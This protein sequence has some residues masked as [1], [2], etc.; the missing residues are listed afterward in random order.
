MEEKSQLEIQWCA[1]RCNFNENWWKIKRNLR[2]F[3]FILLFISVNNLNF[4]EQG[5]FVSKWSFVADISIFILYNRVCQ[6][7]VRTYY[8][9]F[10]V[11]YGTF[12]VFDVTSDSLQPSSNDVGSSKREPKYVVS[13]IQSSQCHV[14]IMPPVGSSWYVAAILFI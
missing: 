7:K 4:P 14:F 11:L 12:C 9:V 1:L 3:H 2:E 13:H 5:T 6:V 8:D 10:E